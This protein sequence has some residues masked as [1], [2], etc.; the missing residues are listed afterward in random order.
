M[1]RI[2]LINTINKEE[3][4]SIISNRDLLILDKINNQK[5]GKKKNRRIRI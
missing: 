1:K 2:M 3:K 4:M 5:K